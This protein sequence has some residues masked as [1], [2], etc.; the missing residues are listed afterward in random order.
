[1]RVSALFQVHR[2]VGLTAGI[3]LACNGLTGAVLSVKPQVL[4]RFGPEVQR[5]E[6]SGGES[7][8]P[9]VLVT[10][11]RT[12][13]PIMLPS[14]LTMNA[15]PSYPVKV[16]FA[17]QLPPLGGGRPPSAGGVLPPMAGGPPA[18]GA[19]PF[20]PPGAPP[21]LPPRAGGPPAGGP[22]ASGPPG[23]GKRPAPEGLEPPDGTVLVHP[24]TGNVLSRTTPASRF[25]DGLLH[26]HRSMWAGD[27]TAGRILRHA[28]SWSVLMLFFMTLSGLYMRWPKGRAASRW[29]SWFKINFK[30]KGFPFLWNLHL[31]VGTCVLLVYLM[32]AHTGLMIGRQLPWYRDGAMAFRQS[33]GMKPLPPPPERASR[34]DLGLID[35]VWRDF[36]ERYPTFRVARIELPADDAGPLV[37]RSGTR[38]LS[39]E[40]RTAT[41]IGSEQIP[42]GDEEANRPAIAGGVANLREPL[43]EAFL[44]GN[45]YLHTGERWGVIGQAV[46]MC[47]GL[48]MPVLFISGWMMYLRRRAR[49]QTA[50]P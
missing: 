6:P 43:V 3:F 17:I 29:R 10:K 26:I 36:K 49:G 35:P 15:D 42:D 21:G 16:R 30:L 1:M 27:G 22:P 28:L 34:M 14:S 23:G 46:M 41:L 7:L 38:Q 12:A 31:V 45:P 5:I 24:V 4:A 2:V 19:A 37:I 20:P 32:T 44:N 8:P 50:A 33:L 13:V 18:P 25:Y 40:A 48:C 39:Y 47:A 9:S 11:A